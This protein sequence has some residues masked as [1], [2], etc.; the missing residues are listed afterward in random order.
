[1][2]SFKDLYNSSSKKIISSDNLTNIITETKYT[3][4]DIPKIK[5]QLAKEE[6]E[7][8]LLKDRQ[9]KRPKDEII[10]SRIDEVEWMIK[11][12][13]HNLS[14]L[15]NIRESEDIPKTKITVEEE[16]IDEGI[17]TLYKLGAD[18]YSLEFAIVND[19]YTLASLYGTDINLIKF[20]LDIAEIPYDNIKKKYPKLDFIS[21]EKIES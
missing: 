16:F 6:N 11:I 21:Y 15:N 14:L 9:I 17:E 2:K 8:K 1:M 19:S 4:E 12:H 10:S 13:K 18:K 7:L 3:R 5:V 20:L